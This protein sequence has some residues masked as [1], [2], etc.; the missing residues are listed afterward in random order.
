MR[1]E[2]ESLVSF[3]I[4]DAHSVIL[5]GSDQMASVRTQ[6]GGEH[7]IG[8][9]GQRGQKRPVFGIPESNR[10]VVAGGD[11]FASIGSK[12]DIVDRIFLKPHS[13]EPWALT[14]EGAHLNS[15]SVLSFDIPRVQQ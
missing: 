11:H 1:Q 13:N 4:P 7:F 10:P 3:G 12:L 6:G 15:A 14:E 8:M 9:C 5:A 2:P